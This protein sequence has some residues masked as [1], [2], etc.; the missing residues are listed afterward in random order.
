MQPDNPTWIV[1]IEVP[2]N[3]LETVY[4]A[5]GIEMTPEPK[6]NDEGRVGVALR[7]GGPHAHGYLYLREEFSERDEGRAA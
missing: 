5:L 4:A 7:S 2:E 6:P 3:E 1:T